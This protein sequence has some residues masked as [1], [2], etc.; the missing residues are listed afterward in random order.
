MRQR[1]EPR[2]FPLTRRAERR[3]GLGAA[4]L[5]PPPPLPDAQSQGRLDRRLPGRA[6]R[7]AALGASPAG[8]QVAS[9]SSAS[10]R[11][12]GERRRALG[13][14]GRGFGEGAFSASGTAAPAACGSLLCTLSGRGGGSC[15]ALAACRGRS[16]GPGVRPAGVAGFV[17]PSPA[18]RGNPE[19]SH[20]SPSSARV[21][22]EPGLRASGQATGACA[23][24][25]VSF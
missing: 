21:G 17:L 18:R 12:A 6:H 11:I 8:T 22:T 10:V 19:R 16:R 14:A 5:P 20:G 4:S 24:G 7:V 23:R 1:S 15:P 9:L 25:R 3:A 13:P 2:S